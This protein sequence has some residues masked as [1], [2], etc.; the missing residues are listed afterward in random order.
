M[1]SKF[2]RVS[3]N[4]TK[5]T[6]QEMSS[7]SEQSHTTVRKTRNHWKAPNHVNKGHS[8]PTTVY[9]VRTNFMTDKTTW[10]PASAVQKHQRNK[11]LA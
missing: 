8:K 9:S 1:D 7:R 3:L 4:T 11:N 5:Q 2:T 6:T 10:R